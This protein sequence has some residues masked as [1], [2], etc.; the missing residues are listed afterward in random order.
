MRLCG[1]EKGILNSQQHPSEPT[2]RASEATFYL[3]IKHHAIM[4]FYIYF[5][6]VH[7]DF[8][9]PFFTNKYDAAMVEYTV[10]TIVGIF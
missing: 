9:V 10:F 1:D 3:H 7:S 6:V 8:S 5:K 4:Y 2:V